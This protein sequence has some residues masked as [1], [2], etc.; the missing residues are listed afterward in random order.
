MKI[1]INSC[2]GGFSISNQCAALMGATVY[3]EVST[4]YRW[5]RHEWADGK[6][7][8]DFRTD[9]K[10]IALIEE[11][12]SEWCSGECAELTI[13]EIPDDVEW[14]V[15]EYDGNEWVSEVHRTWC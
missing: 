2:Y 14:E 15:E 12:G 9:E 6:A 3:D 8:R 5:K 10:L 13:V 7:D 11:K 4:N 1:V